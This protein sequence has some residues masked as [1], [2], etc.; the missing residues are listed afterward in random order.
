MKKALRTL[1]CL[2][3][4]LVA[5]LLLSGLP[6]TAWA[7]RASAGGASA[8]EAPAAKPPAAPAKGEAAKRS[9]TSILIVAQGVVSDPN[10][11][12]S[13]VVVMN[14]L[15]PAPV[16]II[17]NRPMPLTV[18]RLFP[19]VKRLAQVDDKVYFGG[20]VEFP[21]VWYLFRAKT[22]PAS[23]IQVC[24]GVYVSSDRKFL[25]ELLD[26]RKPM[27]GLRI[28]IGH[29]G[30]APGQLQAEIEGGAWLPRR[31]DADSIFNAKPQRPWPARGGAKGGT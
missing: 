14:N 7:A 21:E 4:V 2:A 17:V 29:A 16:G 8:A 22:A 27:E 28:Y 20:P 6:G 11:G 15:G 30:W 13:I 18:A 26:R 31:A 5:V 9:L 24:A 19:D 3:A 1:H 25:L 10:F 23:A 12:G